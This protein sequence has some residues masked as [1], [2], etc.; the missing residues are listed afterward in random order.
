MCVCVCV[1]VCVCGGGDLV[2]KSCPTLETAWTVTRQAPLSMEFSRQEYWGGLPFPLL[3]H[4]PDPGLEPTSPVLQVD[5]HMCICVCVYS[6]YAYV[7]TCLYTYVCTRVCAHSRPLLC[8]RHQI[9]RDTSAMFVF[10]PD[11]YG[12]ALT[13]QCDG[14]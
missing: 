2:A 8:L 3:G 4:L 6:I 13:P 10:P 12:E 9:C 5:S 14:I 1:C 11:S 7:C